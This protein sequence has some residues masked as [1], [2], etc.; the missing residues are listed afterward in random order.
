VQAGLLVAIPARGVFVR[1]MS[2]TE[3]GENYDVRALLTGLMC[4]RA[5]ERATDASIAELNRLIVRMDQAIG[6]HAIV[7]YY[8]ANLEFHNLI[9][10]MADHACSSRISCAAR[11]MRQPR[12]MKNTAQSLRQ[13]PGAMPKGRAGWA[14]NT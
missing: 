7:A 8:K 3:I 6:R 10:Q 11:C 2:H 13:S 14:R 4:A 1:E 5:A 9:A 12:P